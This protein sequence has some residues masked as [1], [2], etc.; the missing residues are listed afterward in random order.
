MTRRRS[1]VARFVLSIVA[2]AVILLA[3]RASQAI[4]I[5]GGNI[6]NQTWRSRSSA[7]PC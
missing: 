7:S 5:V 3:S 2:V 4:T 1:S 6:I